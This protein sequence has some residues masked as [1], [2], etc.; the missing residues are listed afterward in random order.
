MKKIKKWY[1]PDYDTHYEEYFSINETGEY[2]KEPR[3][4]ALEKVENFRTALDIGGNVGFWSRDLC[5]LFDTVHI[6]EPESSNVECLKVN[7]Q[8]YNNHI[9]HEIGLG[10]NF[11]DRDFYKSTSTS[12]G[13]T[14]NPKHVKNK[15]H[16]VKQLLKIA[17][18]DSYHFEHVDFIKIDT[19]G[20][21]LDILAGA[22]DT[23]KNNDCVVNIE[24][25]Q[26]HKHQVEEGKPIFQFMKDLGFKLLKRYKRDEVLFAKRKA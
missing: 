6:F 11:E 15:N 2:Q 4:F 3:D 22:V 8:D 23:L 25:E 10:N 19:Q 26:K 20:S 1:V 7:L 24:I 13:H 18:L 14:L 12:G 21:E 9:I 16:V 17:P 5:K